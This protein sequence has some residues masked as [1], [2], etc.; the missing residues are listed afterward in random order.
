MRQFIIFIGL[1]L[2]ALADVQAQEVV[3]VKDFT[4]N[5][6]V[7]NSTCQSN[8]TIIVT[9]SGDTTG[10]F[11]KQYSLQP[12]V[13]GGFSLPPTSG[14]V[15]T[16][17]PPGTYTVSVNA[18]CDVLGQYSV[19]KTKQNV[20][21]GGTYVV[22]Q[23]SF[24]APAATN[25]AAAP[26][27][28]K[29]YA[30]CNT[31]IIVLLLQNG[32]QT[33]TPTFTITYA[34][35]GVTVPQTVTV[36]RATSGSQTAGYRYTLDGQN[37]PAGDY[38]VQINDGCY[39][40]AANF[41]LG[42]VTDVPTLRGTTTLSY[43]NFLPY[44]Q[45]QS[46]S[47][48]MFNISTT[49]PSSTAYPDWYRYYVDGFYEVG[50]AA[51]NGTPAQWS[52]WTASTIPVDASP[53]KISDFYGTANTMSV[54]VRVKG[55]TVQPSREDA[56]LYTPSFGG[57]TIRNACDYW[58]LMGSD[59]VSSTYSK[60]LCYPLNITITDRTT[61]AVVYSKSNWTISPNSSD[62]IFLEYGKYYDV[63]IVDNS[64]YTRTFYYM[65][66]KP[67][68]NVSATY[69]TAV[70]CNTYREGL[71]AYY[72]NCYPLTLQVRDS[73]TNAVIC[74]TTYNSGV[75][76]L[77]SPCVVEY[78]KT[79][80]YDFIFPDTTYI[81]KSRVE[82]SLPTAYTVSFTTN[83]ATTYTYENRCKPNYGTLYISSS[84]SNSRFPIGTTFTVTGPNG[85]VFSY[86]ATSSNYYVYTSNVISGGIDLS[87]GSYTLTVNHGCGAPVVT[88]FTSLGVYDVQN[89]DYTEQLTC[90]G[91]KITPTGT[92]TYRGTPVTTTIFRLRSGPAGYDNTPHL[93]GEQITLSFAGTYVLGIEA[94]NTANCA[95]LTDTIVYTAPPM[96]LDITKTAA[97]ACVGDN[98]GNIIL[99]A[100]NGVTPYTYE[101][102]NKNL[103]TRILG[104]VTSSD[105]V[106]FNYGVPDSAY[107][108]RVTDACGN[109]FDQ[110]ISIANLET[111]K[112]VYSQTNPACYGSD[113]QLTCLTLGET[114]YNW[115]G[116][117]GFTSTEQYPVIHN[118]DTTDAGWYYISVDAE[119]C[120]I[121]VHDSI[122]MSVYPPI[123][124]LQYAD[125]T[126]EVAFCP[127]EL[128]RLGKA[129]TGGS[130]AFT[131]Q[132]SYSAN[133]TTW[134]SASVTTPVFSS[135]STS[136][137]FPSTTTN[138]TYRY[139][140]CTITDAQCGPFN[141]YY[142]TSA[143][144][145]MLPVNPDLMNLP[146][147]SPL[148][149]QKK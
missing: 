134:Y 19:M 115:T 132:W 31:G 106:V 9:L 79:Y 94:D 24:V 56:Y 60:I 96:A 143:R 101:L 35:T 129:A 109:S 22:P 5:T 13:A 103:T 8:G 107:T 144:P 3:C 33:T 65:V 113:M 37:Y 55:C 54:Y 81:V 100:A 102:W 11:T 145:C 148:Q 98:I 97:Y 87:P 42:E 71:V 112:L 59:L 78:G 66:S 88:N 125:D 130:G 140:R 114:T 21:V 57:R 137:L 123:D 28:R 92:V 128:I 62:S 10:L 4:V 141:I 51:L 43:T 85:V 99:Q 139:F 86:T 63:T 30:G 135:S 124:M 7:T 53:N 67:T 131:Y 47:C 95:L 84:N 146:P 68:P 41:T 15:L 138:P 120:G 110:S 20:V 45:S 25:T 1:M 108:V 117:K 14:N 40:A 73:I 118:V 77:T 29:S 93:P 36:T 2:I 44:T 89:L 23:L 147:G 50:V 76:S 61:S 75:Y 46:S 39:I 70:D 72:S 82:S 6:A 126:L 32:N 127:R 48:G 38:V 105:R 17:I 133:G 91:M 64:S 90:D 142:H 34:P 121:P 69:R 58:I 136:Y 122:Y 52:A 49:V 119:F 27:S 83:T 16:G 111:A 116:P 74:D 18:F 104:P 26:T 149:P 12:S 80:Y